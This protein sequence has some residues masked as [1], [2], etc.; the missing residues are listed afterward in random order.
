MVLFFRRDCAGG[1][2]PTVDAP[3]A[4]PPAAVVVPAAAPVVVVVVD[5]AGPEVA[6]SD[7]LAPPVVAVAPA[8]VLGACVESVV[9]AGLPNS[10]PVAAAG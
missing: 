3:R 6:V 2:G 8:A 7:G 10:A 4:V 9:S 1:V 5:V